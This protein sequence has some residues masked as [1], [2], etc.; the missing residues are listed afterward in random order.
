MTMFLSVTVVPPGICSG[1]FCVCSCFSRV[2][3]CFAVLLSYLCGC[4]LSFAPLAYSTASFLPICS[5]SAS[6]VPPCSQR[7]P[8]YQLLS[9]CISLVCIS[10]Q[11]WVESLWI[12]VLLSVKAQ[13][14]M[15]SAV[16]T[17]IWVKYLNSLCTNIRP[18][19]FRI[20]V[21]IRH[22]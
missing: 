7:L 12:H 1:F 10:V 8:R 17:C 20:W 2:T 13:I 14:L 5:L 9:T 11:F 21:R 18:L 6:L 15:I 3:W 16:I 19:S 4:D 22:L